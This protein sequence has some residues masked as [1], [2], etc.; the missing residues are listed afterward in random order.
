MS[1]PVRR[2]P[3]RLVG[4]TLGKYNILDLIGVGGMGVVYRARHARVQKQVALKILK[5]DLALASPD[6]IRLFFDEAVKAGRLEH[7]NII[8]VTDAGMSEEEDIVFLVMEWLDGRTL[9]AELEEKGPFAVERVAALLETICDAADYAHRQGLIHRDLKPSNIMLCADHRGRETVKL[10]DFG[11]AKALTS[12]VGLNSRVL[13]APYYASPE[14]LTLSA[15]IDHRSDIYSLGVT[16]YQLLTGRLPFNAESLE[17]VIQQHLTVNPPEMRIERP[18]LPQ[19]VEDVVQRALAKRPEERYQSV[20]ELARAFRRAANVEPGS[21]ALRCTN[22]GGRPLPGV[23][24]YLDGEYAGRTDEDGHLLR[25]DLSPGE[26]R[27]EV[28]CPGYA[29]AQQKVVIEARR[30]AQLKLW[31]AESALCELTVRTGVA[32]AQVLLNGS[33]VGT[34]DRAGTLHLSSLEAGE[35]KVEV[36]RRKYLPATRQVRV[37]KRQPT[38]V[39]LKLEPTSLFVPLAAWAASLARPSPGLLIALVCLLFVPASFILWRNMIS[40]EARGIGPRPTPSPLHL[41]PTPSPTPDAEKEAAL[42]RMRDKGRAAAFASR[43]DELFGANPEPNFAEAEAAYEQAVTLEPGNAEYHFKLGAAR[44]R[45]LNYEGAAKEFGEAV[46]LDGNDPNYHL[47]L[48]YALSKLKDPTRAEEVLNEF[49]MAIRLAEEQNAPS[50]LLAKYR[51]YYRREL[52]ARQPVDEADAN[53]SAERPAVVAPSPTPRPSIVKNNPAGE[54]RPKPRPKPT[55]DRPPTIPS[56]PRDPRDSRPTSTGARRV[57]AMEFPD[58]DGPPR[59]RNRNWPRR[60][61]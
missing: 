20:T 22:E 14:Q 33:V 57:D 37:V 24:L 27:V 54:S 10:L 7:P 61:E 18:E 55:P 6:L 52:N 26:Y 50:S 38:V 19:E 46:R 17:K 58:E 45:L 32:K 23:A 41:T 56:R 34:T 11:I 9:D 49:Q 60:P 12:T 30:E 36:R 25:G 1:R 53:N 31:L 5:P 13:G 48:G 40:N 39:D 42:A 43:G 8:K 2:D 44:L 3:Y 28:T 15:Q 47:N 59:R 35:V 51:G 29:N 21:L 16:T 4:T